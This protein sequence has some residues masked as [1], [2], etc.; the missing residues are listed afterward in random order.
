MAGDFDSYGNPIKVQQSPASRKFAEPTP[1]AKA[2]AAREE[3]E[4]FAEWLE[5]EH[6]DMAVADAVYIVS[7]YFIAVRN[8]WNPE[9]ND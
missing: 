3:L 8:G 5:Y 2:E 4:K 1:L 9:A 7:A 6:I